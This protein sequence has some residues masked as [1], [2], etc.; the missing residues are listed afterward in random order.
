MTHHDDT[1]SSVSATPARFGFATELHDR[2]FQTKKK[3]LSELFPEL[4]DQIAD[5]AGDADDSQNFWVA[6]ANLPNTVAMP[7][8]DL[9]KTSGEGVSVHDD[10][11]IELLQLDVP[12]VL[13]AARLAT[14]LF[15]MRRELPK[16]VK[17][18]AITVI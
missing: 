9:S 2:L 6:E 8:E 12:L 17:P 3:T 1:A 10:A 11:R 18:G 15:S 5:Q 16:M 13:A 4:P 7:I 14:S